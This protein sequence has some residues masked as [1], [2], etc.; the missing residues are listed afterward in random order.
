MFLIDTS[1]R[2]VLTPHQVVFAMP[3]DTPIPGYAN[4]VVNTLRLWSAMSPCSFN[5]QFCECVA[6]CYCR[7]VSVVAVSVSH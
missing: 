6:E 3:Y 2:P 7:S 5:L 1:D 4:N